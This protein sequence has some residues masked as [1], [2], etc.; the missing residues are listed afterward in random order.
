MA[1][2]KIKKIKKIKMTKKKS[3]KKVQSGK[4]KTIL[5]GG[6]HRGV[7]ADYSG[8]PGN[9]G[10]KPGNS[11]KRSNSTFSFLGEGTRTLGKKTL[12]QTVAQKLKEQHTNSINNAINKYNNKSN[13]STLTTPSERKKLHEEIKEY[14]KKE[15]SG[16]D[17]THLDPEIK[18]QIIS[19]L[20][21]KESSTDNYSNLYSNLPISR[22]SSR[23][24]SSNFS[25]LSNL[26]ALSRKSSRS[27]G[28]SRSS[29]SSGSSGT[30]SS[31][32]SSMSSLSKKISRMFGRK[33]NTKQLPLDLQSS[34]REERN[35]KLRLP[36]EE[37]YVV[38]EQKMIQEARKK[39]G[40]PLDPNIY[41]NLVKLGSRGLTTRSIH[42]QSSN[43]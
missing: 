35:E 6:T 13:S 4:R 19:S 39:A 23:S 41:A 12:W 10:V 16:Y 30:E 37:P 43:V 28:S 15:Y 11:L 3:S 38:L 25:N 26:S 29:R 18:Q 14:L 21:S 32:R 33:K 40:L 22:S 7:K 8:K 27:S 36:T 17:F 31:S 20:L 9:S 5:R 24:S 42:P 1:I 34:L 2:S